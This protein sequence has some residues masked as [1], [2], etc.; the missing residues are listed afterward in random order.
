[1]DGRETMGRTGSPPQGE[2]LGGRRR[3]DGEGQNDEESNPLA[4]SA[5][6]A[7]STSEIAEVFACLEYADP[8]DYESTHP[9]GN[10]CM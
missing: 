1:M 4:S 8:E 9:A 5:A 7:S 10:A 3:T 6:A 2:D